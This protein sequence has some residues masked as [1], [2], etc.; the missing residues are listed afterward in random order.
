MS[1]IKTAIKRYD[2]PIL[3]TGA[4][5]KQGGAVAAALLRRGYNVRAL[6]RHPEGERAVALAKL[7]AEVVEAD[8]EVRSSLDRVLKDVGAVFSV[9][10]FIE[11]GVESEK[12]QGLNLVEAV[13]AAHPEHIIYSAAS[14][15][16]RNTGV[17]HL[18]S[19][20]TI[21]Q[22]IRKLEIPWTIFRPTAFMENWFWE[23][24]TLRNE[25]VMYHP[26]RPDMVYRQ[27]SVQDIAAMVVIAFEQPDI[28]RGNIA[29]LCGDAMTPPEMAE[30]FARVLQKPIRYQ[31]VDW[32]TSKNNYGNDLTEMYRYF[33]EFGMDGDPRQ[34]RYWHPNALSFEQFLHLTGWAGD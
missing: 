33:D 14:T 16:D 26:G 21:E 24:E 17:P 27:V 20:W 13:T 34:L 15:V 12:R 11:T 3:V 22:Q 25:G 18:E 29:S 8:L 30:T 1:D 9:Q 23:E 32:S 10:D 28:W 31:Q 2:R 4:T 5:G 7:G 19:K 6:T